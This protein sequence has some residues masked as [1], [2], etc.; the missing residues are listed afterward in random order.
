MRASSIETKTMMP[1][2]RTPLKQSTSAK[3][4]RAIAHGTRRPNE[5]YDRWQGRWKDRGSAR[6]LLDPFRPTAEGAE[7]RIACVGTTRL[8]AVPAGIGRYFSCSRSWAGWSTRRSSTSPTSSGWSFCLSIAL[9]ALFFVVIQH[10]TRARWS[11]VVRRIGRESRRAIPLLWLLSIPIFIGMH[12][13]FT[14]RTRSYSIRL[15]R[16]MMRWSR[17]SQRI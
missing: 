7:D 2:A 14:G 9:G 1:N 10:L 8:W 6:F 17:G 3:N 13:L 4:R 16:N 5:T 12:D 11:V 15:I